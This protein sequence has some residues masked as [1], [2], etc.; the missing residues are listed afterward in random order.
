MSLRLLGLAAGVALTFTITPAARAA[1]GVM[2]HQ[3]FRALFNGKDLTGWHGMSQFDPRKLAAMTNIERTSQI[4]LRTEEAKQ[5]RTVEGG[6]LEDRTSGLPGFAG[7]N[8]PVAFRN[9][10]IK[11]LD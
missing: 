2:L 7:H 6:E 5:H 1:D 4:A 9:V 8:D 3:S 11:P 10:S